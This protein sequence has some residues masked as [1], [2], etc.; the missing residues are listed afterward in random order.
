M[1]MHWV[2]SCDRDTQHFLRKDALFSCGSWKYLYLPEKQEMLEKKD[3]VACVYIM[4]SDVSEIGDHDWKTRLLP[5][6]RNAEDLLL[7]S[8][9]DMLNR[10]KGKWTHPCKGTVMD[11]LH[12]LG[13]W[14]L[15]ENKGVACRFRL[16]GYP[17]EMDCGLYKWVP[18]MLY[19]S[20]LGI[21]ADAA[22]AYKEAD[23]TIM[24]D[25]WI[26]SA[27]TFSSKR[28]TPSALIDLMQGA[29]HKLLQLERD[30]LEAELHDYMS[31]V[32]V[33]PSYLIT[34][35]RTKRRRESLITPTKSEAGAAAAELGPSP[36]KKFVAPPT[37]KREGLRSD[38][39]R[40][41][42]V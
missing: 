20:L 26:K 32:S 7:D 24:N 18:H 40:K 10:S 15:V 8:Y 30:R 35:P 27:L 21:T 1:C 42:F 23:H 3:F 11:L 12:M 16:A 36:S 22:A 13:D 28:A 4:M 41:L 39:K 6:V 25:T 9:N 31:D 34:P 17:E 33:P 14:T 37:L 29:S 19:A 5:I 2:Y 38:P